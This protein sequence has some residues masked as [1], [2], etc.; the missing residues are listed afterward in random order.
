MVK[1]SA[2]DILRCLDSVLG[3]VPKPVPLHVPE[4]HGSERELLLECVDTGWVSSVGRFV[5]EFEQGIARASGTEH[6]IAM[7]NGTCA[8]EIA[9]RVVDVSPGDEVLLPSLT[10]VATANA[11]SHIGAIPHFV[12]SSLDTL[13]VDPEALSNHLKRIGKVTERGVINSIT[14]RRIACI[15]PMH[16]FGHPVD[17]DG[18]SKIGAEF[19]LPIVED[20][21]EALGSS[22]RGKPAGGIGVIGALSFNGNKII[23]TGGGGAVVT[24]DP[25]LAK[26]AK[27]LSTTAKLPHSWRFDHDEVGFNYRMPNINAAL[28]VAQLHQLSERVVSKRKLASRY[29]EGFEGKSFGSIFREPTGSLSNYWLN[30]LLLHPSFSLQDRDDLIAEITTK[31]YLVRP[32]WTPMHKLSFY[33]DCPRAKLPTV[34]ELERRIINLPSSASLV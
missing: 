31:G 5:E 29:H 21:A 18:L 10:F 19:S 28:G 15:V 30:T 13:G 33:A 6:G 12:D 7:V 25:C 1:K 17:M 34:E 2:Q 8:L 22:Y 32:A 14:N 3:D 11:V 23:T 9:L 27:H 4:F 16:T 26:R 24:N 20:A